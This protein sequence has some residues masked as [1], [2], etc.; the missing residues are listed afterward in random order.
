[1]FSFIRVACEVDYSYANQIIQ[2]T[3]ETKEAVKISANSIRQ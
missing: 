3:M 2:V 1:M